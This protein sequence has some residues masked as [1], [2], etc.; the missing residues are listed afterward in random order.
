[1]LAFVGKVVDRRVSGVQGTVDAEIRDRP[2]PREMANI[3]ADD[4]NMI[5]LSFGLLKSLAIWGFV[6]CEDTSADLNQW[7]S[8]LMPQE[9][10]TY[11][12]LQSPA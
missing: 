6:S 7:L 2:I 3:L 9:A 12:C 4:A 1:M 8:K 10:A 11:P 5:E